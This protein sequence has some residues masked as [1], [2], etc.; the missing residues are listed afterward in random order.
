MPPSPLPSALSARQSRGDPG[1]GAG[2]PD[3]TDHLLPS[4]PRRRSRREGNEALSKHKGAGGWMDG[5]RRGM[6]Y[7][8]HRSRCRDRAARNRTALRPAWM[9]SYKKCRS[10]IPGR[11][12]PCTATRPSS[13][14]PKPA[15]GSPKRPCCFRGSFSFGFSPGRG[16]AGLQHL[17]DFS[18]LKSKTGTPQRPVFTTLTPRNCATPAGA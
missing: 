5:W 1:L 7:E 11:P 15:P 13:C 17:A 6:R 2:C 12:V 3:T 8:R 4:E 14:L 10:D 9:M 18:V 16:Q